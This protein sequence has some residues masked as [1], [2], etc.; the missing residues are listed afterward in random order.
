MEPPRGGS[1]YESFHGFPDTRFPA[2]PKIGHEGNPGSGFGPSTQS[3]KMAIIP[4]IVQDILGMSEDFLHSN[5]FTSSI[6]FCVS[7]CSAPRIPLLSFFSD[8]SLAQRCRLYR[9]VPL[10]STSNRFS[11]SPQTKTVRLVF[12]ATRK[13]IST[14]TLPACL[15]FR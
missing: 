8:L 14:R 7:L 1:F 2:R 3:T 11:N 13:S 10:P 9:T 12:K 6:T 15:G 4:S 5:S